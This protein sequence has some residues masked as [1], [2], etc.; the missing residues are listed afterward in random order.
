MISPKNYCQ[1]MF[2]FQNIEVSVML[3]GQNSGQFNGICL[4]KIDKHWVY[5][6]SCMK[7]K[8]LEMLQE[9]QYIWPTTNSQ[10]FWSTTSYLQIQSDEPLCWSL[11]IYY[12]FTYFLQDL[13]FL[14]HTSATW[15]SA[16]SSGAEKSPNRLIPFLSPSA[17]SKACRTN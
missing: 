8:A 2:C 15:I 17:C 6:Y 9:C 14:Q 7:P 10:C 16:S 5:Q 4:W 12:H 3:Q 11:V 13:Y 1:Y